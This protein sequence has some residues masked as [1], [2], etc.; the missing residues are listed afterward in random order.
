MES[1][2]FYFFLGIL[3]KKRGIMHNSSMHAKMKVTKNLN[4]LRCLAP[5]MFL[6]LVISL[7]ACHS[8]KPNPTEDSTEDPTEYE[9]APLSF[10]IAQ[11][12]D[13]VYLAAFGIPNWSGT[14][15]HNG[16]DLVI[17]ESLGRTRIISPTIGVVKGIAMSENPYSHP[18]GQLILTITVY[19][20]SEWTVSFI[21]EPGTSNADVKTTQRNAVLVT[22]GQTVKPGDPVVD[23]LVGEF[24]HPC[25]HF[26][27]IHGNT[28]V[29]AYLHSSPQA[30]SIYDEIVRTHTDSY[31]PNGRI[32][33]VDAF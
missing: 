17:D 26:M 24:G 29:C 27:V 28:I 4:W 14:E 7:A 8:S 3:S 2:F 12:G 15:P 19:V 11:P 18:P 32:C 33:F 23:L 16:I 9:F 31:L 21:I 25:L 20:N 13:I 5:G 22:E 6:F 10:P 30:Q 1:N